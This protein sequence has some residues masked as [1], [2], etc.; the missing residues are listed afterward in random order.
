M[1]KYNVFKITG[2]SEELLE[3][4]EAENIK[5]AQKAMVRKYMNIVLSTQTKLAV[6]AK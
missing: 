3:T 6:R 1:K 4:V 2:T 5:E